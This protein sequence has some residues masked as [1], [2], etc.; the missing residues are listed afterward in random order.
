[1]PISERGNLPPPGHYKTAAFGT[2]AFGIPKTICSINETT[3]MIS[4][5]SEPSAGG[6]DVR[7]RTAAFKNGHEQRSVLPPRRF[8]AALLIRKLQREEFLRGGGH[9]NGRYTSG[10]ARTGAAGW[11]SA[12]TC[13][14]LFRRSLREIRRDRYRQTRF[15]QT[16]P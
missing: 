7:F 2:A 10:K 13:I 4:T 12:K 9:F 3:P 8:P 16:I 14:F 6:F 1:M 5:I 11:I 15:G